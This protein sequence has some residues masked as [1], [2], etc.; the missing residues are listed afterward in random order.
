MGANHTINYKTEDIAEKVSEITAGKGVNLI[1]DPVGAQNVV[2][3]QRCAAVDCRWV[4]YGFLGG[5]SC[6]N[7]DM[8]PLLAKRI[9][10]ISTTLKSRSNQYKTDLISKLGQVLFPTAE[11]DWK[12]FKAVPVIEQTFGMSQAREAHDFMESNASIGKILLR[13]DL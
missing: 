3:N 5:S 7:F 11:S 10:L 13:N 9:Q 12:D 6:D 8:R 2:V 4:L 1:A